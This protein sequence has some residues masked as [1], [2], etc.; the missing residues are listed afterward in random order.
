MVLCIYDVR[1]YVYVHVCARMCACMC[2]CTYV[3]VYVYVHVCARVCVCA[4]MCAC[5]CMCTYVR[6]KCCSDREATNGERLGT[7]ARED[8]FD[9][10]VLNVRVAGQT[11]PQTFHRPGGFLRRSAKWL[12]KE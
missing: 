4:R 12:K 9:E 10:D 6:L 1:V 11:E 2:M 7:L 3:H 8:V 5:M